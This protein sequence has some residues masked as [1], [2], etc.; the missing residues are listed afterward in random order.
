MLHVL[1][2]VN[3]RSKYGPLLRYTKAQACQ[4]ADGQFCVVTDLVKH[5]NGAVS[6][7]VFEKDLPSRHRAKTLAGILNLAL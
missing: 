5:P 1:P 4:Q 6:M 7:K 3:A 2:Q